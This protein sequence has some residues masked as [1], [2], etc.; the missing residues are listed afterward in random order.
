MARSGVPRGDLWWVMAFCCFAAVRVLVF[1]AAFPFFNNVDERRHFDLVIK[2]A[3]GHVPRSAELIST[4]TLPYLSRYA[5]PEFL[6]APEHFEGGYYG[7]MWKHSAEEVAP[8]IARIE[9]IWSRTL[10]QECS[11]PPLYYVAAAAWFHIG[12]LIGVKGGYALYWVRFLN[13]ALVVTLVWLAYV[14]ARIIFPDQVALRLGIPLLVASIPQDAF[15]GIDND[16]LSPICFGVTFICLLGWVREDQHSI[17]LGIG[18]GLSIAASYLTKLSNLPLILVAVGVI[19]WWCFAQARSKTLRGA[20]PALGALVACAAIPIIAWMFWMKSHFGDFTGAASK[21]QL[22]GWTA[23]PFSDWWSHP[24]FTLSGMWTFLSELIASFWRGEFMWHAHTIGSKGMDLFYVF[25]S[26]GLIL[27]TI[28]SVLR[29]RTNNFAEM[30]RRVLWIAVACVIATIVFLAFL[31]LQFDFG[32]CINPSRER[33]YFFQG[34]L[35]GGAMIP[36]AMLYV[37]G[38]HRLLRA[39]PALVLTATI[40]IAITITI[41][42]FLANRVAFASEYNCFHM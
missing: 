13:V 39:V 31:S 33:P 15:Y 42:E 9:E 18:T 4:A 20:I 35:L 1:S 22:L 17:V 21:A 11:Q 10:N 23:K 34:R 3:Y 19:A 36:F 27:I 28:A 14:A 2:Y 29:T 5:S 12:Q 32:Q 30:Q 40:A 7:P 41:S 38:L 16:V 37:Y 8:T 24:I 26:L 25:S 6:S